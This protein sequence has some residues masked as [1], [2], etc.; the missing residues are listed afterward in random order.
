MELSIRLVQEN[1]LEALE[2]LSVLAWEPVFTSVRTVLGP[3]IDAVLHPD[4]RQRQREEVRRY[5]AQT[6]GAITL[7]AEVD[8]AVAGFIAYELHQETLRGVV[9]LLAVHPDYQNR[10]LGTE[11]NRL[12]LERMRQAGMRIA[13]VGTGGDP[14]HA[15]AR[16]TYEKAGYTL[17]PIAQYYQVL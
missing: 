13:I 8:G 6:P 2:E 11:L 12:V 14:G 17:F 3:E 7:V 16:R 5:C 9:D 10:G 15:P 4:W 1:D